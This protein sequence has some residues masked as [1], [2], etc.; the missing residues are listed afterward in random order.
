MINIGFS[1]HFRL[2]VREAG[3]DNLKKVREFDNL[4][5]NSGLDSYGFNYNKNIGGCW[6][7]TGTNTPAV[8]DTSLGNP[9]AFATTDYYGSGNSNI[10]PKAPDWVSSSILKYR[11][12]VGAAT[13]N[14][15]EVGI[16]TRDKVGD[17]YVLWSRALILNEQG[18][19]T[20]LTVLE[21]EYLDVYYTVKLH[22]YLGDIDF[23]FNMDDEPYQC[24]ARLAYIGESELRGAAGGL[25]PYGGFCISRVFNSNELGDITKG[26]SGDDAYINTYYAG[27]IGL[28]NSYIP[29]TYYLDYYQPI[30]LDAGNVEG[31]IK[32]L[33][34]SNEGVGNYNTITD[35]IVI[36]TQISLDHPILKDNTN[37]IKMSFRHSWGRYEEP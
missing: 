17:K 9:L 21:N 5:T 24:T 23:T 26:L 22:P 36:T 13:G 8:T 12:A 35:T 27:K 34:I 14:L 3:T 4:I 33:H 15:T 19:P 11:F 28:V 7:G 30:N 2:E 20:S 6:V 25:G 1:G 32:G 37:A 31:G 10:A 18:I 16:T 29:G